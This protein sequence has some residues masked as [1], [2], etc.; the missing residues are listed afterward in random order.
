MPKHFFILLTSVF[1]SFAFAQMTDT[2][3][4][5][6]ASTQTT[7]MTDGQISQV[8]LTINQGE[9]EAAK[10]AKRHAANKEIKRF[11]KHMYSGHEKNLSKTQNMAKNRM[12]TLEESDLSRALKS[13]ADA[14]NANLKTLKKD[15]MDKT[16]ISQQIMMHQNALKHLD[17]TLIP[18]A[19][20][21]DLRA[22]LEKTRADVSSHLSHAQEIQSKLQ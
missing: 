17:D 10:W 9:I 16:Y 13:E 1:F 11:A 12:I 18:S 8:L 4:T 2:T 14:S 21:P 6:T 7:S 20:N 15:E 5:P 19:T 3:T 22:H